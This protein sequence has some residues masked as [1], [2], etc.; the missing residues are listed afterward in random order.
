MRS[1]DEPPALVAVSVVVVQRA[2]GVRGYK[3]AVG[4]REHV[5]VFG[6]HADSS[7]AHR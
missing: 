4:P 6:T 7:L 5:A 3:R 2:D 1:S